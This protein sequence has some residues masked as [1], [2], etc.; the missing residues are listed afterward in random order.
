[1]TLRLKDLARV[2]G[3][4]VIAFGACMMPVTAAEQLPEPELADNGLHVQ[5]WF[6]EGFLEL[7]DDLEEAAAE[8]KD[9]LI[10]IEQAGC[11]YCR[12][13]HKVNL[14]IPAIVDHIKENFLV[15]QLDMRGS[16]EVVDFDGTAAEERDL[17]RKWGVAFTPTM[18]FV[19]ADATDAEGTARERAAMVM[20]G[21]FKPFHFDTMMHFIAEDAY[22]NGGDFQR[23]LDERAKTLRAQG[24]E[25]DVW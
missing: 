20:P 9:L 23:F 21:Y 17:V 11:P 3:A 5:D 14:R 1:M 24:K 2:T 6:H 7:A 8:G 22:Q 25:V 4:L 16:R 10:L 15:V 19:P 13:M 12:E 18:I